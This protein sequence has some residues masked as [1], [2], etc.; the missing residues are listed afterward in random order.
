MKRGSFVAHLPNSCSLARQHVSRRRRPCCR[1]QHVN[2]AELSQHKGLLLI[3]RVEVFR[4]T[5]I[6]K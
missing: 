2:V 4:A 5:C 3:L 6:L 1:C